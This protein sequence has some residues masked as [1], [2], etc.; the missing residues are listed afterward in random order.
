MSTHRHAR[1]LLQWCKHGYIRFSAGLQTVL[2]M[3][4]YRLPWRK[5]Y[6]C[7]DF[8]V[9]TSLLPGRLTSTDSLRAD[10]QG[11]QYVNAR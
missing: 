6:V 4:N 1:D 7:L 11:M 9:N 3:G 5:E 8:S 10:L 2:K